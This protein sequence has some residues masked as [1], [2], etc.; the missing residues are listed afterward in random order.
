MRTITIEQRRC[1]KRKPGHCYVVSEPGDGELPLVVLID[2]PIP[3]PS[4][5]FRGIIT[6]DL[7]MILSGEEYPAYLAG[8]SD[9][10]MQ[11]KI[12]HEPEIAA[13]G[14]PLR[15]RESIG[16]CERDGLGALGNVRLA[17]HGRAGVALRALSTQY[18]YKTCRVEVPVIWRALQDRK[19][20]DALAAMWRLWEGTP[21]SH[22]DRVRIYATM[23]MHAINADEDA[24]FLR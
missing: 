23:F 24:R 17:D 16:V 15:R 14:M 3:Y 9:L 1:G 22:R 13:Y 18:R 5:Q 11:R 20:L 10:H 19:P 6:V 21:K 12:L 4:E 7:D 2:P 8:S